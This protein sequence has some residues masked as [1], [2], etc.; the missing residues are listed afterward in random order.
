MQRWI[1]CA[2]VAWSCTSAA[3][4]RET[5]SIPVEGPAAEVASQLQARFHEVWKITSDRALPAPKKREQVTA[6][7]SSLLDYGA[8]SR[9]ALGQMAERFT[10]AQLESFA[11]A[12]S[13][14]VTSLLVAR[15]A[16][17]PEYPVEVQS[18]AYDA[19]RRLVRIG[20]RGSATVMGIPG[21]R[22]LA[23]RERIRL[24]MLLRKSGDRWG[25]VALKMSDVDVST[26]FRSQF[27]S[28]LE[29]SDPDTLIA[30]LRQRNE[31]SARKNPFED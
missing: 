14:Y 3:A 6:I 22:R 8:L 18:A 31:Q 26:N 30:Q 27:S 9:A 13:R 17:H 10:Q 11:D 19:E 25:I 7:V 5:P 24:E 23:P 12:Y 28:V 16:R 15:V 20:A 29:R 4:P 1:G 2:L 21:V